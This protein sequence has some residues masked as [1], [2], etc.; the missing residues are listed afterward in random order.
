MTQYIPLTYYTK[1]IHNPH[2]W[3]PLVVTTTLAPHTVRTMDNWA[4]YISGM[5]NFEM[6][7]RDR[8]SMAMSEFYNYLKEKP[9]E[10]GYG[11]KKKKK[12]SWLEYFNPFA[13]DTDYEDDY[14][15]EEL[16]ED[17]D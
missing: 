14:D 4:P 13:C 1:N 10:I 15:D 8:P 9:Y 11:K 6:F 12:E 3:V 16:E 7:H 5:G 2:G 17:D